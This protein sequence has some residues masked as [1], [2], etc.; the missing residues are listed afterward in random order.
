MDGEILSHAHTNWMSDQESALRKLAIHFGTQLAH[1]AVACNDWLIDWPGSP[2]GHSAQVEPASLIDSRGDLAFRLRVAM[3]G[4]F[5]ISAPIDRWSRSDITTAAA[6]V[7]LYVTKLRPLVHHGN[8]FYLTHAPTPD[9][10]SAWAAVWYVAKDGLSGV[11]FAFRLS[12]GDTKRTFQLPGLQDATR[13]NLRF[14]SG[15]STTRAGDELAAGLEI[16]LPAL[17][18]SELCLVERI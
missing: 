2:D 14:G 18:R 11:L 16:A 13:Y 9:G 17:C 4:T 5:G 10:T 15:D 12:G 1:P 8:Q 6:H 3:L 7:E